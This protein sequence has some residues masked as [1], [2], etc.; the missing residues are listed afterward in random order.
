MITFHKA[1]KSLVS[2][3]QIGVPKFTHRYNP[4]YIVVKQNL[5][6]LKKSI[7]NFSDNPGCLFLALVT[8]IY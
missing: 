2:A 6:S 4:N 5:T 8:A 1:P 3:G 7:W